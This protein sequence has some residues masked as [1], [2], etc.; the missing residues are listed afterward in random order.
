MVANPTW[1]RGRDLSSVVLTGQTEDAA[2]TYSDGTSPAAQTITGSIVSL[3]LTGSPVQSEASPITTTV[4]NYVIEAE[5]NSLRITIL[6][7][8]IGVIN[9][10]ATLWYAYDTIKVVAVRKRTGATTTPTAG[11]WTFYG[12]RGELSETIDG[13]GRNIASLVLT[14]VDIGSANPTYA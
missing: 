12:R 1:L 2:G 10:L 5:N 11:T 6:L 4:E 3:E 13:R 14:Q 7:N 8:G 9:P